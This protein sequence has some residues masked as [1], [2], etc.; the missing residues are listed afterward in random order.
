MKIKSLYISNVLSF[1]YFENIEHATCIPFDSDLNIFIGQN[2]AGKSTALE[3]I[4]FIFKKVIFRHFSVNQDFYGRR[5]TLSTEHRRQI[6]KP[7]PN[8][9]FAEFRLDP[10]W[11][12]EDKPQKLRLILDLDDI[13]RANIA[14]LL[15]YKSVLENFRSSYTEYTSKLETS[16]DTQYTIDVSLQK[17]DRIFNVNISPSESPGYDYLLNYNFYRELISLHNLENPASPIAP[18]FESYTLIGGYRNYHAFNP[19]ISLQG[20]TALHQIQEIRNQEHTK[21][22]NTNEQAEPRIFTLVRLRVAAKHYELYGDFSKAP[23][24]EEI[25]NNQEFLKKINKRLR[26]VNLEV[27]IKFANKQNWTYSFNF[28][29][30]RRQRPLADINSLSAGQKAIVHLVFEAYGRGDLKG[31]LVIIDEPEIHLHYQFQNEYLRVIE[32]IN[33]EQNC[34]YVLVTHS[35]SLISSNTIRSVKRFA[36]NQSNYTNIKFPQ[37]NTEERYLVKVL[38]NTKSTYAFFAKKVILVEG[39]DDR[40]FYSAL[41]REIFPESFQEIAILDIQGKGQEPVWR[42]FFESYGLKVLFIGDFDVVCHKIYS[43]QSPPKL[44][45]LSDIRAFKTSHP[46]VA[47]DIEAKYSDGLFILKE[48]PLEVYLGLHNKSLKEIIRY[49]NTSLPAE[50]RNSANAYMTELRNILTV[51]RNS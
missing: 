14:H 24:S 18:L 26:I 30:L 15:Q 43:I 2:G 48:G 5:E 28:Y 34:Q 23:E 3:A 29:D 33:A 25:A 11:D 9:S 45:N 49:C 32:E 4:N 31:G 6:I 20:Q 44:R 46:N 38:D 36:L 16:P 8:N 17:V 1:Q 10:N 37:I 42:S 22:L 41:L 39:E 27:R 50:I 12:T 21:S 40:Y 47:A 7:D 51:I 13:D 35:E 19:T